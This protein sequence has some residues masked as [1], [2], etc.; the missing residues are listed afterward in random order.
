MSSRKVLDQDILAIHG[1]PQKDTVY[2]LET[3][4]NGRLRL[5]S[6][7]E[8]KSRLMDT[9]FQVLLCGHSHVPRIV[10]SSNNKIIV[11]PGSVGLQAYQDDYIELHVMELG[12]PDAR[13]SILEQTDN[14]WFVENIV[15]SY[16]H[17]KAALQARRNNR[18]DWEIALETGYMKI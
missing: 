9:T 14:N 13:Y 4:E 8:I 7:E 17:K 12:S 3:V 10:Y 16:E 18:P 11:N 1:T 2:L 6:R 15:V 5:S